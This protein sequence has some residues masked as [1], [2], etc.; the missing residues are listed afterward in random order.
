MKYVGK[1]ERKLKEE[2]ASWRIRIFYKRREV[3]R[4]FPNYKII[5]V[6]MEDYA[7]F[8]K[9]ERKCGTQ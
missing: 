7:Y 2:K 5:V 3:E 6:Q 1:L 8:W 9:G 4:L